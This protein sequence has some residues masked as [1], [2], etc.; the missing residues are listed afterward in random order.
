[1]L[2]KI[3][4]LIFI[5]FSFFSCKSKY[6]G[7]SI[8]QLNKELFRAVANDDYSSIKAL[9]NE[10][11]D[12]NTIDVHGVSPMLVAVEKKNI[13]MI[14]TL[15]NY[16][17]DLKAGNNSSEATDK[18]QNILFN[19]I[20]SGNL[21]LV[22]VLIKSGADPFEKTRFQ[23]AD[24]STTLMAAVFSDNVEMVKYFIEL[25]VDINAKDKYGDPAVN[26][27]AFFTY[28]AK[29]V[30]LLIDNGCDLNMINSQ[31]RSSLDHAI[32]RNPPDNNIIIMLKE[33]GAKSAKEL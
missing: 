11:A 30:K 8:K 15:V 12:V 22:K 10:G 19:A 17:A 31:G 13:K 14:G 23:G 21:E 16:G 3:F 33:A 5:I 27:A 4:F 6:Q 20:A 7:L 28:N 25:D 9:I 26:W 2:K 29:I 1:M 32:N 24:D 18:K